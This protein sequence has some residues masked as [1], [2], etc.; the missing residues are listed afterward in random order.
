MEFHIFSKRHTCIFRFCLSLFF[1]FYWYHKHHP[2]MQVNTRQEWKPKKSLDD[3][4]IL[5]KVEQSMCPA[6][7]GCTLSS[8]HIH[9][10]RSYKTCIHCPKHVRRG[11][12]N[13][14]REPTIRIFWARKQIVHR[15]T[16]PRHKIEIFSVILR[17]FNSAQVVPPRFTAESHISKIGNCISLTNQDKWRK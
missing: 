6:Q 3:N 11:S 7:R 1:S 4:I 10:A 14:N 8:Y 15:E 9:F 12:N 17:C 2:P 16:F 13:W 5:S